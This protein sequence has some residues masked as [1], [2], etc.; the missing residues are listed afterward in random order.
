MSVVVLTRSDENLCFGRRLERY[1]QRREDGQETGFAQT[2]LQGDHQ[3]LAGDAEARYVWFFSESR[4]RARPEMITGW[5]DRC[6]VPFCLLSF[7]QIKEGIF[8]TR[9]WNSFLR[10]LYVFDICNPWTAPS[11]Y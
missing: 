10:R 9:R 1:Q 11:T 2:L 5:I 3:I 8:L 6:S 7:R 4:A